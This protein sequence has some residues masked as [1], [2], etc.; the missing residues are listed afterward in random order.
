[1]KN[2]LPSKTTIGHSRY[3]FVNAIYI[4]FLLP[5]LQQLYPLS[6]PT[7]LGVDFAGVVVKTSGKAIFSNVYMYIYIYICT[8]MY[9]YMYIL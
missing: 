1:M 3:F 9:V 2:K 6:L 8:H 5:A 4:G 7:I